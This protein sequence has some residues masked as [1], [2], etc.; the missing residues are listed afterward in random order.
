MQP[1]QASDSN[2]LPVNRWSEATGAMHSR[3]GTNAWD[4]IAAKIQRNGTYPTVISAG[5]S[6]WS[7]ATDL[8]AA[9]ISMDVLDSA[10]ASIDKAAA[11]I[12][13]S[14][15]S[16]GILAVLA[17]LAIG[18]PLVRAWRSGGDAG[19]CKAVG[20]TVLIVALFAVMMN[21]ASHSTTAHT[22]SGDQFKPGWMSP[23][24]FV[25]GTNNVISVVAA[26]PAAA[27][28]SNSSVGAGY[29]Y[30]QSA[31]GDLSC[32]QYVDTLK[33]QY[34]GHNPATQLKNSIPLV[35][36]SMWE[37]TGLL[38]W[39]RSQFGGGNPY[40]DFAYCRLLEQQA[41]VTPQ[42]QR[43]I[44]VAGLSPAAAGAAS[45]SNVWSL[46]WQTAQ[47]VQT[48]RTMV[49]WGQCRYVKGAWTLAP[50]WSKAQGAD[51]SAQTC[52]DWWSLTSNANKAQGPSFGDGQSVFNWDGTDHIVAD[53]GDPQVK[54]YLLTLQG[55]TGGATAS[56][57]V[58]YMY[59]VA[60]FIMFVV[61]GLLSLGIVVA[62]FAATVM[63]LLAFVAF[64]AA[65]VPGQSRMSPGKYALQYVGMASLTFGMQLIFALLTLLTG[66]FVTAGTTVLDGASVGGMLWTALAPLVAALVLHL[67]F[68]KVLRVPSPFT[69]TGAMKWGKAASSGAMVGAGLERIAGRAAN[70]GSR[71]LQRRARDAGSAAL[72]K[73]TGGRYGGRP[74]ASARP[75]ALNPAAAGPA[76]AGP[77]RGGSPADDADRPGSLRQVRGRRLWVQPVDGSPIQDLR[78]RALRLAARAARREADA[79]AGD[80]RV[81]T[82]VRGHWE[83]RVL[84][85]WSEV[86]KEFSEHKVR[87]TLVGA[88]RTAGAAALVLGTGGLAAPV[89]ASVWGVNAVQRARD[90]RIR[91]VKVWQGEQTAKR[92][93][94]ERAEQQAA[95]EQKVRAKEELQLAQAEADRRARSRRE[96]RRAS[97]GPRLNGRSVRAAACTPGTRA[98]ARAAADHRPGSVVPTPGYL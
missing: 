27:L 40:G 62:K 96:P 87:R 86:G 19:T 90:A 57:A 26:A 42:E 30:D 61:M 68:V 6:L 93:A 46:A 77:G 85:R 1:G 25:V 51:Q 82:G 16:S 98:G 14:L 18:V 5:N 83:E 79:T 35:M 47:D 53:S 48:D 88:G 23:G 64:A 95:Q 22:A 31:T 8:T 58:V 33:A 91:S 76:G 29:P 65:L 7:G 63:M 67:V 69:M 75:G 59:V 36:S 50:G 56:L 20:S 70:G 41:G 94:S 21:G 49:A 39:S 10:G 60:A 43:S 17:L 9:A 34:L 12:G 55:K 45:T 89:M 78:G 54:N 2:L 66:V 24:W 15:I 32:A 72:S 71:V 84:S 38:A 3:L 80:R 44:T 81:H 74:P 52:S 28:V 97:R 73:A 37:S 11:A 13:S 4:D 92:L